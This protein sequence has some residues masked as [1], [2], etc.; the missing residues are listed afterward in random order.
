VTRSQADNWSIARSLAFLA[1]T[2]AIVF[3]SLLPFAALAAATPGHPFVICSAEGTQT[4]AV[5]VDGEH[6]GT[7]GLA[8]VKCAACLLAFAAALPE[9]PLARAISKGVTR[10]AGVFIALEDRPR[11]PVRGPPRPPST[12]PPKA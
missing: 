10:P 7:K 9:P 5:G 11:P 8:G 6:G 2:F 4:I 1:A 3:G 12:A